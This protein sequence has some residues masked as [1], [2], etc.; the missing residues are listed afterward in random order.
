MT[1]RATHTRTYTILALAIISQCAAFAQSKPVTKREPQ[2]K[3]EQ[4]EPAVPTTAPPPGKAEVPRPLP[5]KFT[6]KMIEGQR[7]DQAFPG[8]SLADLINAVE[9]STS[10]KK[11]EFES[12]SDF[13]AR[14]AAALTVKVLGDYGIDDNFAVVRGV[15]SGGKYP[16][17][18]SYTFNPDTSEVSVFVLPSSSTLNGIG[19]P[20]YQTAKR[21]GRGLDLFVFDTEVES[22]ST[23]QGSNAYGAT[24]TVEKT[25]MSHRG[26]AA[27]QVAFLN[28]KRETFYYSPSST[29]QFKMDNSTAAKELPALKAIV[30]FRI[31]EP[32]MHYNFAH[33]DP[34]RD[35]PKDMSVQ[36]KYISGNILGIV[37]YSGLTGEV[38]AR[39][40]DSFGNPQISPVAESTSTVT[41][42][43]KD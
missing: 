27:S 26:I 33:Y 34:K 32:Y 38:F 21:D 31:V 2:T 14:K 24:V 30:V 40:P 6:L 25:I 43:K 15:V 22:Q 42:T 20:N 17:G 36:Y 37:F 18:L 23:Y 9:K 28:F 16:S 39:L 1:N 5:P 35:S 41:E 7:L 19:A 10:V 3:Q 4:K 11:G 29:L 8:I 13:N 12:T